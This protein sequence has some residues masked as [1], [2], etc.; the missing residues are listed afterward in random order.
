M[1]DVYA[2]IRAAELATLEVLINGM[3]VRA[4]DPRQVAIRQSLF[5]ALAEKPR[6]LGEYPLMLLC[7]LASWVSHG[8]GGAEAGAR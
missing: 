2:D 8:G 5:A 6:G 1:S 4:A 3:E 7:G